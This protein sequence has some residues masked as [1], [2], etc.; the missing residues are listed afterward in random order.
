MMTVLRSTLFALFFYPVT[1]LAVL[2][3]FAAVPFGSGKVI[4]VARLWTKAHAFL[5]ATI[6]GIR[7]RVEGAIPQGT[8]LFAAK[9]QSMYETLELV[10]ILDR[11]A[12][13]IKKELA[14]IPGWG[15]IARRYGAVAVDRDAGAKALRA[16]TKEAKA[17]LAQGRPILIF[18]EGTRVSP[19]D[20]PPLQPGFAGLYRAL[21]LPVVPIA[22]DSGRLWGR[23]SFLKRPG[24]ITFRF[25]APIEAGLPRREIERRVHEDINV[26]EA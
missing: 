4:A 12:V 22:I 15:S 9:H 23:A 11:P 3:A 21:D 13:V 20:S 19:G 25:A 14:D 16:M 6:L 2:A 18:P 8:Y 5:A 1:V 26:L 24:V 17:A 10:R 7:T